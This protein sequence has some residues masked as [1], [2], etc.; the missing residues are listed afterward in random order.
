MNSIKYKILDKNLINELTNNAINSINL[1][2]YLSDGRHDILENIDIFMPNCRSVQQTYTKFNLFEQ[3]TNNY[4]ILICPI[5]LEIFEHN[6]CGHLINNLI[7][8]L[9]N[10]Y[11][12]NIVIF[13]WNHDKDFSQYAQSLQYIDN[14]KVINFGY[15]K[16]QYSS[17]ILV[18]FWNIDTNHIVNKHKNYF[19]SFIGSINNYFRQKLF[20]NIEKTQQI[21]YFNNQSKNKYNEIISSSE[22]SLCPRGG[23]NDGGFSYRFYECMHLDTIPVIISNYLNFPYKDLDWHKICIQFDESIIDNLDFMIE[24]LRKKN[25]PKIKNYIFNNRLKFTLGGVQEEVY[26]QLNET[27]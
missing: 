22:F 20:Y 25:I 9:T 11:P 2:D 5:Y 12:N 7:V 3:D 24:I 4:S 18:P 21:K 23:P 26:K 10:L 8:Q 1:K 27:I 14:F 13:Q 19:C 16:L 17:D 15:T 6:R